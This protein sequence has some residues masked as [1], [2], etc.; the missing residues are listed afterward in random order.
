MKTIRISQQEMQK[1]IARLDEL[2]PLPVQNE[3]IPEKARDVV[4]SRKLLSVIGLEENAQTPINAQAPIR[5]AAGMTMT[6]AVCPPGQGPGLHAHRRTYETFTV[7][8]GEFE[9]SWND[10]GSERTTLRAF[11]TISVP[12]GVCRAFRNIGREEGILQV[13]ITGG[14][15]DMT[16]IAFSPNARREIEAVRPGLAAEFERVGF[17]FDAVQDT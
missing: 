10:E 13:I 15:H 4:Y 11:D 3:S 12:P 1:R 2:K 16:D 17:T 8:K 14:V 9:V 5:G 7:L 6:L